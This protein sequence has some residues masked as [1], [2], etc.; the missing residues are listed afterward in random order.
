MYLE[1]AFVIEILVIFY[2]ITIEEKGGYNCSYCS[3]VGYRIMLVCL[4]YKS[5]ILLPLPLPPLAV[6]LAPVTEIVVGNVVPVP[7]VVERCCCCCCCFLF[8]LSLPLPVPVTLVPPTSPPL[9]PLALVL[10][11]LA[12][13]NIL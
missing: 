11:L 3:I 4:R 1:L 13:F 9:S 6:A 12:F 5:N 2:Q 10:V 8:T 7:L